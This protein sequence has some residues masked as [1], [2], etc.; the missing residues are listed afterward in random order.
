MNTKGLIQVA[1]KSI[2][3]HSPEILTAAGIVSCVTAVVFTAKGT[4]KAQELIE[5][6]YFD[7]T[8]ESKKA[9]ECL[10]EMDTKELVTVSWKAYIPAAGMLGLGIA[11]FVMSNRVSSAR[12][13]AMA[14]A[15]SLAEKT[16]T[17]YQKKVVDILGE[18]KEQEIRDEIAKDKLAETPATDD[19]YVIGE[20]KYLCFDS[21]SGRYFKSDR[22]TIRAAVN[23][24]NRE[25]IGGCYMDLNDWFMTVGLPGI[26]VGE[27]LGWNSDKLLDVKFASQ[28][29]ANGEPCI[30]LDYFTL[31]YAAYKYGM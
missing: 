22:E 16:L 9:T 1:G 8:G 19:D 15:Y 21:I 31:P 24:F 28:I 5:E 3:K 2:A 18:D 6:A 14:G 30:V 11:C 25:L 23:D 26:A 4:L 29:A 10:H 17:T 12:N 7:K 20:G 13:I 27:Q